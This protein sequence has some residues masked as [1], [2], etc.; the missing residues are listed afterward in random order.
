M[1]QTV[2]EYIKEIVRQ[3]WGLDAEDT[4]RDAD[5]DNATP[6]KLFR[7]V[8]GWKLGHPDWADQMIGWAKDCGLQ[9]L[10]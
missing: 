6:L 9:R 3:R 1:T 10:D 2:P 5:I 4:S 7:A 8:C